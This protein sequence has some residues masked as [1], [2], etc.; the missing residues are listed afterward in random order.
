MILVTG[1]S[2]LVGSSLLRKLDDTI[3]LTHRK[4]V[5]TAFVHGDVTRPWLGLHPA[6]Y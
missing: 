4:P 3:A 1:A 6:D 5:G 2:G